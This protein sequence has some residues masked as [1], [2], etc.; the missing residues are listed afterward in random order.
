MSRGNHI[1]DQE[2]I[3]GIQSNDDDSFRLL[4]ERYARRLHYFAKVYMSN[5]PDADELVQEVFIKLWNKRNSIKGDHNI[6]AFIFKVAVNTVYDMV[7]KKKLEHVYDDLLQ[8]ETS[9]NEETW[10]NIV[11]NELQGHVDR[12][13]GQLPQK[14]KEIFLLSRRKGLSTKEIA[15]QLNISERTVENHIYKAL[16]FLKESLKGEYLIYIIFYYLFV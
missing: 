4:F 7:R 1:S 2:L 8:Y 16:A 6:K 3:I 15:Q 11:Y 5:D 9:I 13:V 14:R 12:L 10:N